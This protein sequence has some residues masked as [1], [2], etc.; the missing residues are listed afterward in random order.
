MAA[1]KDLY[2]E[3]CKSS[4]MM[5][6][7][8]V[9]RGN[10]LAALR[11]TISEDDLRFYF[12]LP[13]NYTYLP[14]EKIILKARRIGATAADTEAALERLYR[15]AFVL[16]YDAGSGLGYMRAYLSMTAE[17]QVRMKKDSPLGKAYAEYWRDLAEK[18]ARVLPTKTPYFRV[19]PVEA[20][21]QKGK[22]VEIKVDVPVPDP[23]EVLP[24]DIASEIVKAQGL[25]GIAE[26]YCRASKDYQ[27]YPLSKTARDLFRFQ[28][29]RLQP[30]RPGGGPPPEQR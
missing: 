6:G 11:Q 3:L 14:L 26:C 16:R 8:I 21:L 2:L 10:I 20:T 13:G 7:K 1:K 25:V 12:L 9:D 24:L 17:Q 18:S 27:G 28:R 30:D 22:Q 4:E 5:L 23:R 19:L 29:F 15:E